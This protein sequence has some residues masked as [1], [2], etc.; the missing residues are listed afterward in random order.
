MFC[1]AITAKPAAADQ[2]FLTLWKNAD[3]DIPVLKQAK[4]EYAKLR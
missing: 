1:K 4:A 3:T 2:D